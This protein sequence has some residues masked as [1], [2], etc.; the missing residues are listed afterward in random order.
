MLVIQPTNNKCSKWYQDNGVRV[1]V[2]ESNGECNDMLS[3]SA[4]SLSFIFGILRGRLQTIL[5]K[6]TSS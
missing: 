6:I 3:D 5:E 2:W 1:G 4:V